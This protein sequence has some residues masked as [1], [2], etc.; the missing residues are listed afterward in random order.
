MAEFHEAGWSE[1]P[2]LLLRL[3]DARLQVLGERLLHTEAPE[4]MPEPGL[5][6]NRADLARRLI[7]D[8]A[9]VPW[10]TLPQAVREADQLMTGLTGSE[11]SFLK[12]LRNYLNG[13]INEVKTNM[14]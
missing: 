10:L 2:A 5:N 12:G 11:L 13:K 7:A 1:R 8:E 3:D 6:R 14:R 4:V 9:T